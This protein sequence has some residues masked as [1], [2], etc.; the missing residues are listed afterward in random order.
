MVPFDPKTLNDINVLQGVLKYHSKSRLI[1]DIVKLAI[2]KGTI[3]EELAK[4]R[5][6]RLAELI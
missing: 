5:V 3:Q 6:R 4:A 2:E 1:S